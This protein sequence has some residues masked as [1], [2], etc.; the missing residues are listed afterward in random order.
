MR[1]S[2]S[3]IA[4]LLLTGCMAA[5]RGGLEQGFRGGL[6]TPLEPGFD[7]NDAATASGLLLSAAALYFGRGLAAKVRR[8]VSEFWQARKEDKTDGPA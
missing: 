4:L 6:P 2:I 3:M 1:R 5:F 7:M 8:K